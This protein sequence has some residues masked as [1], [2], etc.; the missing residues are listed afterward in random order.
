MLDND[1]DNDSDNDNDKDNDKNKVKDKGK[2]KTITY[3]L[4]SIDSYRFMPDSL[5]NLLIIYLRLII[6]KNLKINL[7]IA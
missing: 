6:I 7:Q 1:N 2:V 3:R 4:K 5:S